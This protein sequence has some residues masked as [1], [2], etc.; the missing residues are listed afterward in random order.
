MP[1]EVPRFGGGLHSCML[2][3]AIFCRP[4]RLHGSEPVRT[5]I[6]HRSGPVHDVQTETVAARVEPS[7]DVA[8]QY[9]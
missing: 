3:V 1:A 9:P 7:L 8:H 5:L 2:S 6:A 4:V